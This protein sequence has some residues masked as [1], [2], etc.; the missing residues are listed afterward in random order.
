MRGRLFSGALGAL[1]ALGLSSCGGDGTAG[2]A[3]PL[4]DAAALTSALA[5][6]A[7]GDTVRIGACRV[8]GTFTVPAG[9]TLAGV[10]RDQSVVVAP[11][12]HPGLRPTPGARPSR[13]VDLSVE[14]DGN[15]G[16]VWRD[17]TVT[18]SIEIERVDVRVQRGEGIA[19][20]G[21][22]QATLTDVN[23]R[24]QV[25][26]ATA[27]TDPSPSDIVPTTYSTHGL[28]TSGVG[29]VMGT[30]VSARGFATAAVM[31]VDSPS[32]W[33]DGDIAGGLGTGLL[34]SGARH[35]V[36]GLTITGMFQAASTPSFAAG[37]V[38]GAIVDTDGMTLTD[39]QGVGIMHDA[40]M[41]HHHDFTATGNAGNSV[42]WIQNV[43][44]FTLDGTGS[45]L[46]NNM[47]A[48]IVAVTSSGIT[49]RDARIEGTV[50]GMVVPT[51]T[52]PVPVQMGD[53]IMLSHAS[54]DAVIENVTLSDNARVGLIMDLSLPDGSAGMLDTM[55]LTGLTVEA[56]GTQF[57]ALCQNG[58]W[59]M[60]WDSGV[61]R[62][63]TAGTNDPPFLM[64]HMDIPVH[65]AAAP[66]PSAGA[67]GSMG[68]GGLMGPLD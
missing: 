19:L 16:I 39:N 6:A 4:C 64:G 38:E 59:P 35:T 1:L 65:E 43:T 22:T 36:N 55:S 67:V 29:M 24:G 34:L 60:G 30:N 57:G 44:S 62:T 18:G 15:A 3:E 68:L 52:S 17:A 25:T 20:E 61:M 21:V 2:S 58:T 54:L 37:F 46:S 28:V 9:V 51:G 13:L 33:T 11:M 32:M 27:A 63:G 42:L 41:V 66:P 14:N 5:A 49:L 45:L 7:P 40:A 56:S 10:T 8:T 50:D 47:H 26:A 12:D 48:G 31:L 23:L 53:G